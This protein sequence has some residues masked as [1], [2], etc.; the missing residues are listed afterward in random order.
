[1]SL[2]E[3]ENL[4]VRYCRPGHA[5]VEALRGVSCAVDAGETLG[6][7]GASGCG[8]S[9]LA[10]AIVGLLTPASGTI[11]FDGRDQAAGTPAERLAFRRQVQM[12][13][14]DAIG[15]LN[16]RRTV[17]S[18]LSEV[19]RVHGLAHGREAIDARVA[20]LLTQVGLPPAA[21]DV[22]PRELSG[23]QCQR[24]SLARAL[25]VRPRMIVADE[26]VSALD[27]SVQARIIN[28]LRD[29]QQALGLAVVLI[30]HDLAV[31]RTVCDRICVMA[32][33]KIVEHGPAR[34]VIDAPAHPHTRALI[35]AVPDVASGAARPA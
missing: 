4:V 3:V 27:V 12:V 25:A 7:V 10:R 20:E 21:A 9:T 34:R 14:Q 23:G 24:V 16:P 5:P 22:Y 17:R 2:L 33:G 35:E 32:D 28:L 31:V 18:A 11:R 6:V 8:K 30:S 26:P 13:F 29:L 15:S 19:L 1:M